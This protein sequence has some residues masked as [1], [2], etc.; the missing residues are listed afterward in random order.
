MTYGRKRRKT[1]RQIELK[2]ADLDFLDPADR[3]VELERLMPGFQ[4]QLLNEF[5]VEE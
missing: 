3:C 1:T 2:A 5:I 4:Q